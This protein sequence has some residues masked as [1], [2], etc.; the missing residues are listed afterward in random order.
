MKSFIVLFC[1]IS[2]NQW[3]ER[4]PTVSE[5]AKK[6]NKKNSWNQ[7]RFIVTADRGR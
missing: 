6:K 4:T 5:E 7:Y 1:A 3:I 2:I